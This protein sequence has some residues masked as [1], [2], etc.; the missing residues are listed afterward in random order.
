MRLAPVS[1]FPL[2]LILVWICL[3]SA[4]CETDNVDQSGSGPGLVRSL[5]MD[6]LD[7]MFLSRSAL[8]SLAEGSAGDPDLAFARVDAAM[9]D[10]VRFSERLTALSRSFNDADYL[11]F[12]DTLASFGSLYMIN[13]G[14]LT[15]S[16]LRNLELRL[17]SF[18][19]SVHIL[20]RVFR[21]Y[22]TLIE[23][24]R[25]DLGPDPTMAAVQQRIPQVNAI[26]TK[27]VEL[28]VLIKDF[29]A[30]LFQISRFLQNAQ[31]GF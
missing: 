14:S 29:S 4:G 28:E 17:R 20:D 11:F 9:P 31:T 8:I 21:D 24:L 18:E 6:A 12:W 15:A 2:H 5:P 23:Q 10:L 22:L 25:Q 26:T 13:T 27:T 19:N 1:R 30:D 16:T 7:A 3:L